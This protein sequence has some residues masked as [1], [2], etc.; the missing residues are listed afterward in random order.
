MLL[1]SVPDRRLCYGWTTR[2][3]RGVLTSRH[4]EQARELAVWSGGETIATQSFGPADGPGLILVMGATASMLWWPE[5][6]CRRLADAGLRVVRYDNRD[7]GR[8][9]STVP[10]V[11]SYSVE[12]MAGDLQAVQDAYGFAQAHLVGMS[13][14]GLIAQVASLTAPERVASMTLICSEPLGGSDVERPGI[15]DRF[16]GHFATMSD[17][18]WSDDESVGRFLL[19]IARLSS[20]DP[21]AFDPEAS[22]ARIAAELERT[23]NVQTAFNHATVQTEQDWTRRLADVT[24]PTLIIHG[25]RDPIVPLANGRAICEQIANSRMLVLRGVGHELPADSINEIVD[26]IIE[27]VSR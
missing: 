3:V 25:E 27:H 2:V 18:D 19:E 7:T 14:G 16:M 9:T 1:R 5:P 8:S 20:G 26:A 23:D 22:I 13:L 24:T 12:D 21:D 15:D 6:L 11:A 10:G 4:M 17:L